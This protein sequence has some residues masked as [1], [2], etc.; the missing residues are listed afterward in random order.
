M[1]LERMNKMVKIKVE[2]DRQ[3]KI[4]DVDSDLIG[5]ENTVVFAELLEGVIT[6]V[7]DLSAKM[8]IPANML[9]DNFCEALRESVL[10]E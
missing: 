9:I 1:R 7:K 8:G 5:A 10:K 4:F 3:T 2:Y 6:A